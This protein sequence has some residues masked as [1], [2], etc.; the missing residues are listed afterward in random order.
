MPWDAVQARGG[1]FRILR[2]SIRPALCGSDHFCPVAHQRDS[3]AGLAGK[4]PRSNSRWGHGLFYSSQGRRLAQSP[5][6]LCWS[7]RVLSGRTL[8]AS[9]E[10]PEISAK[11][12]M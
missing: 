8:W 9:G 11:V 5:E 7:I 4:T 10:W 1:T 3:E 2:V 12:Y 6:P